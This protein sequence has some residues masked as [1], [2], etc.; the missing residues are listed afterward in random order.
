MPV[1]N[2]RT[3]RPGDH[4]KLA[5]L[6]YSTCHSAY[7]DI[8]KFVTISQAEHGIR[9]RELCP[10]AIDIVRDLQVAGYEAFLVGGSVRDLLLG[11]VPK[12]F[13]VATSATPEEVQ[14][15]FPRCRLIG[16]RFRLAHV[17]KAGAL[18]EVATFRGP[19]TNGGDREKS[20][21]RILRDN[22]FGTVEEDA[23]RRDFT[24]NALFLDP[25]SGDIR[26]YVG[27]YDDLAQ[28]RLRLIGDPVVR[29][30]EDPVRLLRAARFEAKLGVRPDSETEA[31]IHTMA[32]LLNDVPP[33][34]L[35][36]EICKLFLT[37]HGVRSMEALQRFGL[38]RALFPGLRKASG[39][40]K[41]QLGPVL[42]KTLENTDDRIRNAKPVTPA[43]LFAALLWQPV[44]ERSAELMEQG[45]SEY[46]A[47]V[48]A[49][50]E[51]IA[52]QTQSTSIPRRFSAVTRQIWLMQTRLK[53]TRGKRWK[54]LLH[55][56]RFRAAYD[57]LL[58]RSVEDPSLEP[59]CE[60]WTKAQEGIDFAKLHSER[61]AS[62]RSQTRRRPRSRRRRPARSR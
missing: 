9:L 60:F 24:I 1:S 26:D 22:V 13:D 10:H 51:V 8:N 15:V 34:R 44:K 11:K 16:R 48:A 20:N 12:D 31:P 46:N 2:T 54:R 47:M 5:Q 50:E 28:R 52:A 59:L 45:E 6:H 29:F 39:R 7:I 25:V 56:Q 62:N 21:G 42:L 35:F 53:K 36:E 37:G 30:R 40:G 27:G 57:F 14:Q 43:F 49:G 18:I 61:S 32:R 19:A 17:R 41:V 23:I 38:S 55:E 33:A 4:V 58:L 3:C